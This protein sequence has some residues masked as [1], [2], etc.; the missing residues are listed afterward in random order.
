M[1]GNAKFIVGGEEITGGRIHTYDISDTIREIA[2]IIDRPISEITD[3]LLGS[4]YKTESCGDL[5]IAMDEN[6]VGYEEMLDYLRTS[7]DFVK[8]SYGFKMIHLLVPIEGNHSERILKDECNGW[9]QVDLMFGNVEWLKFSYYSAGNKSKVKGKYRT[10]L[11]MSVALMK[12]QFTDFDENES[13]L[14]KVGMI[15]DNTGLNTQTRMRRKKK[16]GEGYVKPMSRVENDD[17][18]WSERYG[19]IVV[20]DNSTLNPD[21]AATL[22]FGR[23]IKAKHIQ[24]FEQ[25]KALVKKMPKKD[26]LL[27]DKLFHQRLEEFIDDIKPT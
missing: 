24:T 11:I 16:S 18:E 3:N 15:F 13:L 14:A 1:S 19:D 25:V 22:I 10:A 12:T 4:A 27:I 17:A 7:Y 8:P 20:K 26:Q 5:D 2:K 21:D 6:K 23:K 9:V